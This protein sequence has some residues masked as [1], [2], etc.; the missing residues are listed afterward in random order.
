MTKQVCKKGE[1]KG[2][3]PPFPPLLPQK[4]LSSFRPQGEILISDYKFWT[5][6][7]L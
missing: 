3:M 1:E 2:G 6:F 4:T 7:T 5:I